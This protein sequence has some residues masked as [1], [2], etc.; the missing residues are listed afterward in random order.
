MSLTATHVGGLSIDP[1]DTIHW[2][3]RLDGNQLRSESP[4]QILSR[5][6]RWFRLKAFQQK[7]ID[8]SYSHEA[9]IELL[10]RTH[11]DF[12]ALTWLDKAPNLKVN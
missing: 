9:I 8:L 2:T 12:D 10:M 6:N 4:D 11:T 5:L 3:G 1:L 7:P